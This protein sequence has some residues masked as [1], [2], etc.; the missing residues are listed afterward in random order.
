MVNTR[1]RKAYEHKQERLYATF[2]TRITKA[3]AARQK[4]SD[5]ENKLE[6]EY[7]RKS[8]EAREKYFAKKR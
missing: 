1:R 4:A 3:R 5:R 7:T 6:A 2:H 8:K